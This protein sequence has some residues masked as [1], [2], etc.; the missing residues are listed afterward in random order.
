LGTEGSEVLDGLRGLEARGAR[1]ATCG[2][3]LEHHGLTERLAI[4]TVGGMPQIVE[5]FATADR[6]IASC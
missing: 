5:M 6:V 4:G 2:T 1:I 3:C